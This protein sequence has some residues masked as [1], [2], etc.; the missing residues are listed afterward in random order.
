MAGTLGRRLRTHITL[1]LIA[2]TVLLGSALVVQ[3]RAPGEFA[4]NPFFIL[5]ALVYGVSLVFITSLRYVDKLPWLT[6]VHF[7]IDVVMVSAC[8]A[9]TGGITSLFTSL[10]VLPIVAASTI[11]FRRGALQVA[12]LGSLLFAGLVLAQYLEAIGYLDPMFGFALSRELPVAKVAQYTVGLNVFGLFAVAFLSGSLAERVRHADVRLVQAS[13]EIADLQFFNQYVID[14]LVSGLATADEQN[15]VLTFNRS[16]VLIS[17]H[18]LA[19]VVGRPAAEVLQ[20]PANVVT[21]LEAELLRVRSKRLELQYKRS[22]GRTIDLGATVAQLPL[23]DG[24]RGYLYTFQ[25]VTDHRRLEREAQ[26]QKRLAAVGEMAAGIAHEIRNPLASMSGSM[27]ILRQE[28]DLSADQAQLMDIVLRESDRLNDTIRSFL[29][30]ARPQRVDV[31]RLDLRRVVDETATLLRNSHE[32]GEDH[33]IE[34]LVAVSPVIV[35]ADENQVRQVVWNLATNGLRAM[36]TGGRLTLSAAPDVD[37]PGGGMLTVT[38][39]GVGI[40][41]EDVDSIFQPFRGS[42]GKGSGLG[43]AIVH[44]IV[45]DYGARIDVRSEPGHGT[46]LRVIFPPARAVTPAP[47][48]VGARVATRPA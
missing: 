28:L 13:E 11:Q 27:Q 46:T 45:T 21:A 3:L 6:D 5:I 18:S 36:P 16:A 1:R 8:V 23:P 14:N 12:A 48:V 25:D 26:L 34:I 47:Y 35:E 29:A 9:V 38:D 41:P 7:A 43:L 32:V 19:S 15:R 44:R 31:Q 2:A 4:I 39:Q 24:R 20:L 10:Y 17:G 37:R 40:P 22:D 42:F 30:Y 33:T